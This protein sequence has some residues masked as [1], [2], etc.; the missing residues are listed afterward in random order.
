MFGRL[1][2]ERVKDALAN[3]TF[4]GHAVQGGEPA[5]TVKFTTVQELTDYMTT[6]ADD[7]QKTV[8]GDTYRS[9]TVLLKR[10]DYS[11]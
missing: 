4:P 1:P 6:H 11:C 9:V 5:A 2:T 8:G 10:F 7:L 3:L